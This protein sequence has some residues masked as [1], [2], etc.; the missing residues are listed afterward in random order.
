VINNYDNYSKEQFIEELITSENNYTE[1]KNDNLSLQSK[2]VL[3]QTE[4]AQL[5][6]MIFGSKSERFLPAHAD[7]QQ[8]L[9]SDVATVET[10]IKQ[11]EINYTRTQVKVKENK[12]KGRLPLPKH[13]P[14]VEHIIEPAEN[15][16]GLVC[17]GKE[18]TEELEFTPGKFYVNQYIRNKYSKPK[19]QGVIIA[20]LPSRPIEKGIAGPGLLASILIEKYVDHLPLHRQLQRF[21]REDIHI[22]PSTIGDWVKY[23]C[24]LLSPL[25]E[26]LKNKALVSQ[27]IMADETPLKVLDKDNDKGIHQGYYWVYR[28][29]KEKIIVFDYQP[30]R[31]REGPSEILKN[32]KGFLQSDGYSVYDDFDKRAGIT[33]LHCMAHAR[34]YFEQ[35]LDND[36]IRSE[37]FLQQVQLL[38]AVEKKAREENYDNEQRFVLRQEKSLSIL[39]GLG[40]WLK[41]NIMQV[42]PKSA[43]GKAIAY[44]LARWDKLC[45]YAQHGHLEIDNNPVENAIRPVALGRKNYLF[46][47][48]HEAAQRAAMVYSLMATCKANNI[49][50]YNWLKQTL[51]IIADHKANKL[52][53][54]LPTT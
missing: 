45:I 27:Y 31:G 41:E 1:L 20:E 51:T 35:A 33:L 29:A 39:A 3:V 40:D 2:L 32:Y 6:R 7:Q 23:S 26:A 4:L 53:E 5:K 42:L 30:N 8:L 17:I 48:S 50:P 24:E 25:Y 37:Y 44:A 14:R 15:T 22:A 9:F 46:A 13:L 38:Y 43:I 19:Q 21:K 11:Q 54:L 16:A 49:E 34:R 47:G 52:A 18:I 12:H 28:A 36:K 10:E